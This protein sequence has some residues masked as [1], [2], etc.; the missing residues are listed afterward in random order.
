MGF[1]VDKEGV[2]RL[3][4]ERNNRATAQLRRGKF[5]YLKTPRKNDKW[6]MKRK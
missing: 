4:F 3:D 2:L 6:E 1:T 5:A